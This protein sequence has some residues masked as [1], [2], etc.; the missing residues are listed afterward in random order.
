[1]GIQDAAT[2][3]NA[4]SQL[5]HYVSGIESLQDT[6]ALLVS[7]AL[8][9]VLRLY[10]RR[11]EVILKYKKQRISDKKVLA[12]TEGL[13]IDNIITKRDAGLITSE[14]ARSDADGLRIPFYLGE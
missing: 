12:E 2:E 3:A 14:Q 7:R 11:G 1:M 10:G 4:G 9:L 5:E 13:A 6:N 8:S